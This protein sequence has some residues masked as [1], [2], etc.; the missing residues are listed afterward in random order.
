[1]RFQPNPTL[2]PLK[3]WMAREQSP[4]SNEKIII[5]IKDKNR[6]KT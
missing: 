4:I 5:I 2:I 6:R 1:M 3:T